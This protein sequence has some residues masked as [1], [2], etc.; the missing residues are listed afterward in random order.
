MA[1]P[2]IRTQGAGRWE[3]AKHRR[4]P[5]PEAQ[6]PD[7]KPRRSLPDKIW[8]VLTYRSKD[9]VRWAIYNAQA[10]LAVLYAGF[11]RPHAWVATTLFVGYLAIQTAVQI[12]LAVRQRRARKAALSP[13]APAAAPA[14]S[15]AETYAELQAAMRQLREQ[16]KLN[17]Q[18][19][20]H[21]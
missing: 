16:E 1:P 15:P 13:H 6:A 7:G 4:M 2:A 8:R 14:T 10:A 18:G 3:S 21:E 17:A 20:T 11:L 9:H 5:L 12:R 19:A